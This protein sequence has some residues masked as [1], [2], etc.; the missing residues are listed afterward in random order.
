VPTKLKTSAQAEMVQRTAGLLRAG[1][2]HKDQ[3]RVVQLKPNVIVRVPDRGDAEQDAVKA[4]R[5]LP[6]GDV[7]TNVELDRR[8]RDRHGPILIHSPVET[9]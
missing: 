7:Q 3:G 4:D 8:G 1:H 6:V 9:V 2:Q 5:P